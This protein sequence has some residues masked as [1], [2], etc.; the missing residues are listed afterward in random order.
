MLKVQEYL[1]TNSLEKLKE[2]HGV[3][4]R[5]VDHKLNLNYDQIESRMGDKLAGECRGLILRRTKDNFIPTDIPLGPTKVLASAFFRF[6]NQGQPCADEIDWDSAIVQEKLDG[7]LI[8]L[9]FDDIKNEWHVATRSISEANLEIQGF[10]FTFRGLFEKALK[11]IGFEF[12]KF[13]YH[14]QPFKTYIFELTSPYNRIVVSYEKTELTLLGIRNNL[15]LKEE[16][17]VD[18][19]WDPFHLIHHVKLPKVYSLTSAEEIISFVNEQDPSEQE[20]VVIVDKNFNRLKVKSLSYVAFN[21][22]RDKLGASYRNCLSLVLEEKVDDC[23]GKLPKEIEEILLDMQEKVGEWFK[24]QEKTYNDVYQEG[25]NKSISPELY[26]MEMK[27]FANALS[28]ATAVNP[29]IWPGPMFAVVRG[30]ADN[31]REAICKLQPDNKYANTM[32][33]TIL[34]AIGYNEA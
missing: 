25:W 4:H 9:Y 11:D 10:D 33:D 23:I 24:L 1:L 31:I 17:I 22:T 6:Y 21:K 32:L 28:R 16:T 26:G 13:V 27:Q 12:E 8:I 30:K 18:K 19:T 15:N 5:I 2:E 7:S 20:G 29:S 14:L 3:K 34:K